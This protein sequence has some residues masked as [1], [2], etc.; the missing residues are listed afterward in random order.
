MA[1]EPAQM[2]SGL[3]KVSGLVQSGSEKRGP[4]ENPY[5][6]RAAVKPPPVAWGDEG[7]QRIDRAFNNMDNVADSTCVESVVP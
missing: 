4:T 2:T 1:D 3:D 7:S 6:E 5:A